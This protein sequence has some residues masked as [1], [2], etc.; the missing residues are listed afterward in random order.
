MIIASSSVAIVVAIVL[1]AVVT[2]YILSTF[3]P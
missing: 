2:S 3:L 1:V